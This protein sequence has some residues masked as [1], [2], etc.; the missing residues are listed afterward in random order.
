[1]KAKIKI[2]QSVIDR[3]KSCKTDQSGALY[4]VI[5]QDKQYVLGLF[6]ND[7]Y[8]YAD[9]LFPSNIDMC[10]AYQMGAIDKEEVNKILMDVDVTDNPIFLSVPEPNTITAYHII[11]N[12]LENAELSIITD[13]NIYADFMHVRLQAPILL[14]SEV[15][16]ES[17]NDELLMIRKQISSGKLAFQCDK[18]GIY[19]LSENNI[20]SSVE[21][22]EDMPLGKLNDFYSKHGEV[23]YTR[24]KT[25]D[26]ELEVLPITMLKK[27][28]FEKSD[29]TTSHAPIIQIEQNEMKLLSMVLQLDAISLVH[30]ETTLNKLYTIL[31]ES[32]CRNLKLIGNYIMDIMTENDNNLPKKFQ[33]EILHFFPSKCGHFITRVLNR[34][35]EDED[36]V[37]LLLHSNFLLPKSRPIFRRGNIYHFKTSQ[38]NGQTRLWNPHQDIRLSNGGKSSHRESLYSI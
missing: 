36:N 21:F 35:G 26:I 11:N 14:T 3:I 8:S 27:A 31:V 25:D 23:D 4:G 13:S 7:D 30:K 37:R 1:M 12:K 6:S 38:T 16:V 29:T 19:I 18:Y 22:N 33:P 17:V 5:H 24:D 20:V 28:T 2:S 9:L 32:A 34:Y 10:G 15:D